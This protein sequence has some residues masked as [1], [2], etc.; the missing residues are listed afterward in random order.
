MC[1]DRID[2]FLRDAFVFGKAPK[3]K[4][5]ELLGSLA[6]INDFWVFK[7]QK[8]AKEYADLFLEINN[9]CWSGLESGTMLK[10]MG[11]LIKYCMGKNI[12]KKEDLFLTDEEVWRKIISEAGKDKHL[13]LLLDRAD[14]KYRYEIV[15]EKDH[16]M[17]S[18]NK[19]RAVDPL[20]LKDG[21]LIRLTE[22]D[23]KYKELQEKYSKPKR[24]YIK[25]LELR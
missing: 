25:F 14:N 8:Q 7:N 18:I 21:K 20:F 10:N 5:D 23:K 6:I 15:D 19:S 3:K 17:L 12:L 9:V 1:A 16:D 4:I 2:Y 24:Y 11:E 22:A 13:K